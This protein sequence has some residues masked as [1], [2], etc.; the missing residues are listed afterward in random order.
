LEHKSDGLVHPQAYF[1]NHFYLHLLV[2]YPTWRTLEILIL[3]QQLSILQRKLAS[4]IGPIIIENS[5]WL[6]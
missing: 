3:H 2:D 6:K 5:H 4:L 1:L